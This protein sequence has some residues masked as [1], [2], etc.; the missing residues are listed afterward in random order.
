MTCKQRCGPVGRGMTAKRAKK[1][2][3]NNKSQSGP[4]EKGRK[5]QLITENHNK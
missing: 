2:G 4:A 5:S 3:N 1:A